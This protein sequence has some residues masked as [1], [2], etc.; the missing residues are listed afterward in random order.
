VLINKSDFTWLNRILIPQME[1]L[2]LSPTMLL[3]MQIDCQSKACP[4][5]C[6]QELEVVL[7]QKRNDGN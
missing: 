3:A 2:R 5:F 7:R 6:R 4:I 1:V